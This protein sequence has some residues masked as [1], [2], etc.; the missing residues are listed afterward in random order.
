[1]FKISDRCE[2]C[3]HFTNLINSISNHKGRCH[4]KHRHKSNT[5]KRHLLAIQPK[6][7]AVDSEKALINIKKAFI[8]I[9]LFV[10]IKLLLTKAIVSLKR[11]SKI[12]T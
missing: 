9:Y 1:V 12:A 11:Q 2:R 7:S 3:I 5:Q 10:K 4:W 6:D 8:G